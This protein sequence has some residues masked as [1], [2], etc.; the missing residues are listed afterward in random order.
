MGLQN[1]IVGFFTLFQKIMK[2][3]YNISF[4]PFSRCLY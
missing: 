1:E 3:V 2:I 4:H